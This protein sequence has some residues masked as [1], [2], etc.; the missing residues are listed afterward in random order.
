LVAVIVSVLLNQFF[1]AS[2]SSLA[3]GKEHLVSLPIPT[4]VEEFKAIIITP[5]FAGITKPK[6]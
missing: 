1:T 3:I 2:G 6:V 4:T 5:N